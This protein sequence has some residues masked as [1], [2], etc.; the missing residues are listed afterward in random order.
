MKIGYGDDCLFFKSENEDD[1]KFF[2]QLFGQMDIEK[3]SR[4]HG[5]FSKTMGK[6]VYFLPETGEIQIGIRDAFWNRED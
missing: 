6:A 1:E 3:N 2:L 4:G 5:E